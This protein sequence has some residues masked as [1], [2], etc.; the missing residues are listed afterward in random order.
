MTTLPLPSTFVF[1]VDQS[2]WC[3]TLRCIFLTI[4]LSKSLSRVPT[5]SSNP[6]PCSSPLAYAGY[7]AASSVPS[8]SSS[9][10]CSLPA[11]YIQ[12]VGPLRIDAIL[13][14]RGASRQ[15]RCGGPLQAEPYALQAKS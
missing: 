5:L 6:Y 11:G 13:G 14:R 12:C 8:S 15:S 7:A 1:G 10:Y 4:S 9:G 2:H 3:H